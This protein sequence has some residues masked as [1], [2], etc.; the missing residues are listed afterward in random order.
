M[1]IETLQIK[2]VTGNWTKHQDTP[3]VA[4]EPILI[5]G[6]LI[7]GFN[8]PILIIGEDDKTIAQI[9]QDGKVFLEKNTVDTLIEK[10]ISDRFP[11]DK[12]PED[13]TTNAIVGTSEKVARADHTHKIEKDIVTT[14]LKD[15]TDFEY[16][17]IKFATEAPTSATPG[18]I[19]DIIIVYEDK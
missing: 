19:G 15:G 7:D 3:T 9:V 2:R 6:G 5:A 16:H 13:I 12:D 11:T 4:G 14:V 10:G 18:N 8:Y 1:D 17:G